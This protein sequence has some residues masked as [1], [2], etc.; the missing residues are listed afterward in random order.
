MFSAVL[1]VQLMSAATCLAVWKGYRR[2]SS[3][4][5]ALPRQPDAGALRRRSCGRGSMIVSAVSDIDVS[6]VGRGSHG[7]GRRDWV[8]DKRSC[9]RRRLSPGRSTEQGSCRDV[10]SHG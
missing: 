1:T 2:L 3:S 8:G 7:G 5:M 4:A 10:G 9:E 6:D